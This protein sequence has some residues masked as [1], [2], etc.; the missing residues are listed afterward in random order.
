MSLRD[1][2]G[3]EL[4]AAQRHQGKDQELLAKRHELCEAAKAKKPERWSGQ[5]RNWS[6][7]G[8]VMLNPDREVTRVTMVA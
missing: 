7:V 4:T 1:E 2:F 6:P 3:D 8:A 5:T